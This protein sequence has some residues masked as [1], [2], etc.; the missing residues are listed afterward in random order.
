MR[1]K[2]LLLSLTV[3][4]KMDSN[5]IIMF[6]LR[7]S[8]GKY[9][10]NITGLNSVQSILLGF[11]SHAVLNII[12]SIL[13]NTTSLLNYAKASTEPFSRSWE[14]IYFIHTIEQ[15]IY[16]GRIQVLFCIIYSYCHFRVIANIS[17][18]EFYPSVRFHK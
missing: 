6:I 14:I 9:I 13:Y 12:M 1:R 18:G 4:I 16:L 5:S 2:L 17:L 7:G 8:I 10:L 15:F 11:N 3:N